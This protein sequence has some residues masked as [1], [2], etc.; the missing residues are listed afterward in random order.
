M[1]FFTLV[2]L[3][4]LLFPPCSLL[5]SV[6]GLVKVDEVLKAFFE[7]RFGHGWNAGFPLLHAL[8]AGDQQ[9]LGFGVLL[10]AEESRPQEAPAVERE[11]MIGNLLFVDGQA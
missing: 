5:R 4:Q 10:L 1:L 6:R 8:I 9:W 7:P 3:G 11:P 2:E